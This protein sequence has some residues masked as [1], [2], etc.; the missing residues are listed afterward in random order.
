MQNSVSIAATA[1][2]CTL[3]A[4]AGST[5]VNAQTAAPK[6]AEAKY[7]HVEAAL[8]DLDSAEKQLRDSPPIFGGHKQKAVEFIQQSRHELKAAIE[9]ADAHEK[10]RKK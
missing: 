1:L 3:V 10:E 8:R 5:S 2:I 6:P 4:G 9:Y 7:P